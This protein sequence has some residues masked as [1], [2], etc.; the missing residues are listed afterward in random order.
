MPKDFLTLDDITLTVDAIE[1][2]AEEQDFEAA[3]ALE[4]RLF[5]GVLRSIARGAPHPEKLAMAAL[6]T[7][8]LRFKRACA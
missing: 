8:N 2:R 7:K 1:A 5:E 3:H 4:D 6:N